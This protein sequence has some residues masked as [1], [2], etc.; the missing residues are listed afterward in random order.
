VIGDYEIGYRKPPVGRRFR[1]GQCGN[2]K[3]RP[4]GTNNLKTDLKEELE[5]TIEVQQGGRTIR[6]S[7]QRALIKS[8]IARGIKGDTRAIQILVNQMQPKPGEDDSVANVETTLSVDEQELWQGLLAEVRAE[9]A[10]AP[11][12]GETPE[13]EGAE[14]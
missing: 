7:K 6:I 10:S 8:L 12:P 5:E 13:D 14:S 1:K 3:G 4:R 11:N 2:P 9:Q